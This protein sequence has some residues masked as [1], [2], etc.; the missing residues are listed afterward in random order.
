MEWKY[1]YTAGWDLNSIRLSLSTFTQTKLL[2]IA[3]SC[4]RKSLAYQR[5]HVG[6]ISRQ[7]IN[8]KATKKIPKDTKS[9]T[10]NNLCHNLLLSSLS[11]I[12]IF[13]CL[14]L[15]VDLNGIEAN[16]TK[17]GQIFIGEEGTKIAKN[18]SSR[19]KAAVDNG[20]LSLTINGTDF[21]ADG[22]SFNISEPKQFCT[23]GQ[24]FNKKGYCR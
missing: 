14:T 1:L 16:D 6:N 22:N 12:M 9:K 8:H 2:G 3:K 11:A 17:E 4:E 15:V 10:L 7:H 24:T 21:V 18:I 19:I 23:K 5:S 20:N 13:E